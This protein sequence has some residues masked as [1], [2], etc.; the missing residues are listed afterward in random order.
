MAVTPEMI[1]EV[2]A[3][4]DASVAETT[5]ALEASGGDV[6]VAIERLRAVQ[7]STDTGSSPPGSRPPP[8]AREPPKTKTKAKSRKW[9][10]A[11]LGL[12][13]LA[14]GGHQIAQLLERNSLAKTQALVGQA[15]CVPETHQELLDLAA[16]A[17]QGT[18]K[19]QELKERTTKAHTT[20]AGFMQSQR[21]TAA[22]LDRALMADPG[23]VL[24][25]AAA[26]CPKLVTD[27]AQLQWPLRLLTSY[28][29][30]SETPAQQ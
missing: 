5:A 26:H 7:R 16:N 29:Q 18:L 12:V 15:L 1:R 20:L 27:P 28:V 3:K 25:A 22:D 17:S 24:A 6:N 11:L 10:F 23:P 2:R 19:L 9:P 30:A 8:P 14:G 13:V 21:L 4:V